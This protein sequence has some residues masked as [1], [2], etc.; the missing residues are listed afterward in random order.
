MSFGRWLLGA[1]IANLVL[2]LV[3]ASA[4]G[5]HLTR[6][7][8]PALLGSMLTPERDRGLRLGW[9]M[10]AVN[11]F[12][13]ALLYVIGFHVLGR[14]SWWLGALAGLLHGAVVLAVGLPALPSWHPRMAS[15]ELGTSVIR[16]LEPPGFF[17]RNYG[18]RTPELV[19]LAHVLF[20][21]VLGIIYRV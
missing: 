7:S 14:S 20:G 18:G 19:L 3:L 15:E 9:G 16:Q 17:A 6:L 1:L 13:F 8:F 2:T 11:G 12:G 4:M 21:A 10:H 5:W